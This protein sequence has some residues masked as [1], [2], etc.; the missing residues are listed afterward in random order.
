MLIADIAKGSTG[1]QGNLGA[2]AGHFLHQDGHQ[3]PCHTPKAAVLNLENI[4]VSII[5]APQN[6]SQT[7]SSS[8]CR[9]YHRSGLARVWAVTGFHPPGRSSPLTSRELWDDGHH[10]RASW[11]GASLVFLAGRCQ[12][13]CHN[14]HTLHSLPAAI[15]F[16]PVAKHSCQAAGVSLSKG[17]KR[18]LAWGYTTPLSFL[19]P[20]SLLSPQTLLS[21]TH[22][23]CDTSDTRNNNTSG[24]TNVEAA[25]C[26]ARARPREVGSRGKSQAQGQA[27][28]GSGGQG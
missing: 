21:T 28:S 24:T 9:A 4:L 2:G 5:D 11:K 17:D 3:A 25:Q 8:N 22:H 15:H 14:G 1:L 18:A 7:I 10:L 27:A 6:I 23:N 19:T 13:Q 20:T 16:G 26:K 12:C